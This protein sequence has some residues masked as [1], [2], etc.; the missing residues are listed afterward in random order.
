ARELRKR[1][2]VL[3]AE[4]AAPGLDAEARHRLRAR[5]LEELR[6]ATEYHGGSV[7]H[8][9]GD[10]LTSVF[11]IPAAHEDDA[12]RAARAALQLHRALAAVDGIEARAAVAT[13]E[14]LVPDWP[15][16]AQ[17]SGEAV[18]LARRLAETAAPG[19]TL[20]DAPT[21]AAHH[22]IAADPPELR[23]VRG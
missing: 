1:A 10:E 18:T 19:E 9:V 23:A 13:G 22:A 20:L 5:A 8:A 11:G 17:A 15:D 21:A 14:L 4:V 6:A 7:A 12:L 2:T 16:A 3:V